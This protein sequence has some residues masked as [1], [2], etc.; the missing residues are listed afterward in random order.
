[1]IPPLSISQNGVAKLAELENDIL[2]SWPQEDQEKYLELIQKYLTA[3]KEKVKTQ[4]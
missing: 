1:M 2:G 4:L 3:L